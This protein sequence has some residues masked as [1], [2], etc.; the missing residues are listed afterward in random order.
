[1]NDLR[2]SAAPQEVKFGVKSKIIGLVLVAAVVCVVGVFFL[3]STPT[4]ASQPLVA[5]HGPTTVQ[6][7]DVSR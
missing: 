6:T 1:V 7:T 3:N 4:N 5:R 2:G